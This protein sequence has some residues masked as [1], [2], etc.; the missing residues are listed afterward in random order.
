MKKELL[1]LELM[2]EIESVE[3]NQ[4]TIIEMIE[5][6]GNIVEDTDHYPVLPNTVEELAQLLGID[7]ISEASEDVILD[8]EEIVLDNQHYFEEREYWFS[9]QQKHTDNIY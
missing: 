9:L 5:V 1:K 7:D 6:L 3:V 8:L 4:N 2:L